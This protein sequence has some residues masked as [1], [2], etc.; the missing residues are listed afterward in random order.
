MPP[1]AITARAACSVLLWSGRHSDAST[2]RGRPADAQR[3]RV[4]Q[5]LTGELLDAKRQLGIVG[6]IDVDRG[7]GAAHDADA[8]VGPTGPELEFQIGRGARGMPG[9]GGIVA[10]AAAAMA[11]SSRH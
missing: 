7:H 10:P 2:P 11:A 4:A 9:P 8:G 1:R 6:D 3:R 5:P